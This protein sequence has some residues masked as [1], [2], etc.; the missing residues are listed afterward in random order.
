M[1]RQTRRWSWKKV[2]LEDDA[3]S[4][5]QSM[6]EVEPGEDLEWH[7]ALAELADLACEIALRRAA[8]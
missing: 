8:H 7:R 4:H 2:E 6:T 3:R 1:T 5:R